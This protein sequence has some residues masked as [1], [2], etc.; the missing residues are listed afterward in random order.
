MPSDHGFRRLINFS[1]AVVAIAITLLVLPLADAAAKEQQVGLGQLYRENHTELLAFVLSFAVIGSFWWGQHQAFERVGAYN[2]ILV[3]A[4]FL[5]LLGIVFLPFPTELLSAARGSTV[6][7]HGVYIGTMLLS[8]LAAVA[9]QWAVVHWPDLQAEE[10]RGEATVIP[11]A[12]LAA[13]MAVALIVACAV[14]AI[15]LWALLVLVLSRPLSR[16]AAA[17]R[18]VPEGPPAPQ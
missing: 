7:V 13:L 1:D 4:M 3:W 11:S 12:I 10:H 16:V 9:Q 14:P 8:S 5:W 17:W 6:A 15:G 18:R 2:G